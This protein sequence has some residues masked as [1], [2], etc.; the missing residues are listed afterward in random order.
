MNKYGGS[1]HW[2]PWSI[3][4][5]H[6]VGQLCNSILIYIKSYFKLL[7]YLSVLL[8]QV[9]NFCLALLPGLFIPHVPQLPCNPFKNVPVSANT[10][11]LVLNVFLAP[12][13]HKSPCSVCAPTGTRHFSSRLKGKKPTRIE[14][15]RWSTPPSLIIIAIGECLSVHEPA[16]HFEL[17]PMK[18]DCDRTGS[19][20]CALSVDTIDACQSG[21]I[22]GPVWTGLQ[23]SGQPIYFSVGDCNS[24]WTNVSGN[25]SM[26]WKLDSNKVS[27]LASFSSDGIT[28][29]SK[30]EI[31]PVTLMHQKA[32]SENLGSS[33]NSQ[34]LYA[35]LRS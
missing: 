6:A 10:I 18:V 9:L 4:N 13:T 32:S 30:C 12:Q 33:Y 34:G 26:T 5:K 25:R 35:M 21:F 3:I 29:F 19:A 16:I 1:H 22:A 27:F 20:E 2:C 24:P 8:S 31:Q 28:P 17:V 11:E 23:R 7:P 15:V 14:H